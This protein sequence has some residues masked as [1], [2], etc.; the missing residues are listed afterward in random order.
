MKAGDSAALPPPQT[1]PS[2][3]TGWSVQAGAGLGIAVAI[4][5]LALL[6]EPPKEEKRVTG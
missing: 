6:A 3:S 2:S 1:A 4:A 5:L